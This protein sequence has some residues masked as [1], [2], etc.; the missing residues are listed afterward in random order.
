[1]NPTHTEVL[2]HLTKDEIKKQTNKEES[3]RIANR[4]YY[5]NRVDEQRKKNLETYHRK[6]AEKIAAGL[7]VAKKPGR[8]RTV[9][10]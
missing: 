10:I 8:P 7:L 1:M 2:P 5:A 3:H 9:G 6:R 4:K